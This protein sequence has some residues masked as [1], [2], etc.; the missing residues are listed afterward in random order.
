MSRILKPSIP[1]QNNISCRLDEKNQCIYFQFNEIVAN[2]TIPKGLQL[3]CDTNS[4]SFLNINNSNKNIASTFFVLIKNIQ[5]NLLSYYDVKIKLFGIGFKFS[6]KILNGI[7]YI[8]LYLGFSHSLLILVPI[9]INI[10]P[11]NDTEFILSS[12]DKN[13]VT[14]FASKIRKL[15]KP[16]PFNLKGIFIDDEKILKKNGKRN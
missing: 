13:L 6:N 5:N 16:E 1:V 15:K 8:Y 12:F 7:S 9:S 2:L 3:F 10:K 4:I 11:L 14:D